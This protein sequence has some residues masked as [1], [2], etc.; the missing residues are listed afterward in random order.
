MASVYIADWFLNDGPGELLT[1]ADR[2][3]SLENVTIINFSFL[4][5]GHGVLRHAQRVRAFRAVGKL[6]AGR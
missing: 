1:A 5:W 6:A 4:A 3:G 2:R